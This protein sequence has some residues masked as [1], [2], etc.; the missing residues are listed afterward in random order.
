VRAA[1]AAL[2]F[3]VP[4]AAY[5]A[6][7]RTHDSGDTLPSRYLPFSL[8]READFDLDEFAPLLGA[9]EPPRFPAPYYLRVREGHYVSA[10]SPA[11]AVL[12]LPVYAG[13]VLAGV[14][15]DSPWAAGLEKASAAAITAL[16][17][18][19]LFL[20][21]RHVTTEG[22]ALAAA[23]LYAFATS[24]LSVSSQALWEHGP[25]QLCLALAL[26]GLT[27]GGERGRAIACLALA[28]A[29]AMRPT[30]LL[31]A[32]PLG[33]QALRER[34]RARPLLFALPPL[35]L[36]ALY[37]ARY[38]GAPWSSG[39]DPTLTRVW[40]STDR[41]AG[42]AG[43]L[44]SPGRGLFVYSPVLVLAVAGLALGWRQ[45]RPLFPALATGAAL[46]VIACSLRTVWWGGFC[47]GPRMLA[48]LLPILC[49]GLVPVLEAARPRRWLRTAVVV[50]ALPSFALHA[51]GALS[52]DRSFEDSA[53]ADERPERLWS[54]TAGPIPHYA[55]R[56]AAWARR[57]HAGLRLRLWRF[58]TSRD[59]Q[60]LAAAYV[61]AEVPA[62]GSAG[63][64][65]AIR[66][67]AFNTGR[68]AW[69]DRTE[70]GRGSVRLGTSWSC[71]GRDLTAYAGRLELPF[72]VFPGESFEFHGEVPAPATPGE[73][74]LTVGLVDE[75]V[76]WFSALGTPPLRVPVRISG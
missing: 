23:A 28:L 35:L 60:G 33:V 13:P 9:A 46:F 76:E 53:D 64:P 12:A 10:F 30:N 49:F 29:V 56:T 1:R 7:G 45:R 27:R 4:F 63:R 19:V 3:L 20:A 57:A 5:L 32:V 18:L 26:W 39:R 34:P 70:D 66:V 59:T 43:L 65:L 55:G 67:R 15:A 14:A 31:L 54:W 71:D 2:A 44:L 41:L 47:Y 37:N 6:T 8:L 22:P 62:S 21:L 68:L 25:A 16:S 24:S 17:V 36:L 11:P 73:C 52:W 61:L 58:P 72:P 74:L 40:W 75:L 48:D 42:L 50:L 38:F 69:L 51:V